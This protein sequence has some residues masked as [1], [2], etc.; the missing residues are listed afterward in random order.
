MSSLDDLLKRKK[1]EI[2]EFRGQLT[3][4]INPNRSVINLLWDQY[5]TALLPSVS[6]LLYDAK[7]SKICRSTDQSLFN[8]N[9]DPLQH[10][11][12]NQN[13]I[14]AINDINAELLF[15]DFYSNNKNSIKIYCVSVCALQ[16]DKNDF[17]EYQIIS[18]PISF[19]LLN[20]P[21]EYLKWYIPRGIYRGNLPHSNFRMASDH[22]EAISINSDLLIRNQEVFEALGFTKTQIRIL[23]YY[24]EGYNASQV[25]KLLS[26]SRR[27]VDK[28]NQLILSKSKL[29]FPLNRF[30]SIYDVVYT[31]VIADIL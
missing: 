9:N 6:L 23:R 2:R 21:V 27:T 18:L 30:T 14:S 26:I 28:H 7:Q 12:P 11:H 17:T 3:D 24:K 10:N 22:S 25:S 31:L 29:L 19:D 13:K 15:A 4:P 16:L 5:S 20:Y 8:L 1:S